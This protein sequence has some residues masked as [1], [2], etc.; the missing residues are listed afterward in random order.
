MTE[1]TVVPITPT[2]HI[3]IRY[4]PDTGYQI[5]LQS[6]AEGHY[7]LEFGHGDNAIKAIDTLT[8]A[9]HYARSIITA[10]VPRGTHHPPEPKPDVGA[11]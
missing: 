8:T 7:R 3:A 10:N 2:S 6:L 5:A 1:H 4:A 11:T 9:L